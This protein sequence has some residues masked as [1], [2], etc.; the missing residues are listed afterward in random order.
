MGGPGGAG[1]MV[2]DGVK[3]LYKIGRGGVVVSSGRAKNLFSFGFT[4]FFGDGLCEDGM[5][6]VGIVHGEKGYC[7]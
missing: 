4:F 2:N 3:G 5:G 7:V 1:E 6:D